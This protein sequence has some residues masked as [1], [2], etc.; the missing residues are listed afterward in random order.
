[1]SC[2]LLKNSQ[3]E[4]YLFLELDIVP[5]LVTFVA[6]LVLGIEVGI[7]VGVVTD[8]LFLLYY[9]ARPKLLI[10]NL[11]V[12][13]KLCLFQNFTTITKYSLI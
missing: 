12:S 10:E 13:T 4:P 11:T 2:L 9:S 6:C 8:V 3:V 5:F 7:L 1:M